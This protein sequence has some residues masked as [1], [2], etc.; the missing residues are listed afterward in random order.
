[1][2]LWRGCFCSRVGKRGVELGGSEIGRKSRKLKVLR[3][4]FSISGNVPR[5][6]RYVLHAFPVSHGSS[7]RGNRAILHDGYPSLYVHGDLTIRV[8]KC[9]N[10]A[11]WMCA[12]YGSGCGDARDITQPVAFRRY[13]LT[14]FMEHGGLS[15]LSTIPPLRVQICRL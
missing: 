3:M 13:L 11:C 12:P 10:S 4:S 2:E 7:K 15:P 9:N 8:Y 14:D 1:M 6:A 5:P